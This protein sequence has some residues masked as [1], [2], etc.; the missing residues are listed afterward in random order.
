MT[1]EDRLFTLETVNC[2]GAC[3]L[4]PIVVVDGQYHG[5]MAIG[6]VPKL[7]DTYAKKE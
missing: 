6:G 1:T 7:I 3:A 4:G 5:N 2:L